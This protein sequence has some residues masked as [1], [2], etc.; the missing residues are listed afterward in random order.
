MTGIKK[1]NRPLLWLLL[2]GVSVFNTADYFPPLYAVKHGLREANPLMDIILHTPY[3]PLVK[4]LFVP[5]LLVLLWMYRRRVGNKIYTYVWGIFIVYTLL[6]VY[7][8]WL[9]WF[10]PL[11]A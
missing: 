5:L 3:F 2:L 9:L 8:K 10:G 4:L 6:M 1:T 11:S 7:Y